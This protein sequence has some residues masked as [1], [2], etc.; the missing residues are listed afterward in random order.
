MIKNIYYFYFFII[1]IGDVLY[2]IRYIVLFMYISYLKLCRACRYWDILL[3][4]KN[5]IIGYSVN[6][7]HG[8]ISC[9]YLRDIYNHRLCA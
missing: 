1:E 9:L 6:L 5:R 8:H 3:Q 7:E 2:I 4:P